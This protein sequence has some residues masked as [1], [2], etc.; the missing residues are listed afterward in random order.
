M[1][2]HVL[3]CVVCILYECFIYAVLPEHIQDKSFSIIKQCKVLYSF[4]TL[5]TDGQNYYLV[6][7]KKRRQSID[8]SALRMKLASSIAQNISGILSQEVYIISIDEK[9][10]GKKYE[11]EPAVLMKIVPG[12]PVSKSKK[13]KNIYIKQRYKKKGKTIYTGVDSKIIRYMSRHGDLARIIALDSFIGYSDRH[14]RN[15]FFDES[16]NRFWAIDMDSCYSKNL[17][18]V[19]CKNFLKFICNTNIKFS[20]KEL[21]ALLVFKNTLQELIAHNHPE[22]TIAYMMDIANE[23][24]VKRNI[25]YKVIAKNQLLKHARKIRRMYMDAKKLVTITEKLI[26]AKS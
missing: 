24:G 18:D 14:T 8:W 26:R 5:V 19:T 2:I 22:N 6:K 17:F 16:K 9:F 11:D 10:P 13:Y 4:I 20:K 25:W 3:L 1:K 23:I 21:L 12:K 15:I 7:Q